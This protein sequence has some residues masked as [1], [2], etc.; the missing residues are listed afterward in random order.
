[1]FN[2]ESYLQPEILD[3]LNNSQKR[4]DFEALLPQYIEFCQNTFASNECTQILSK[5]NEV[6][7]NISVS[8]K[9]LWITNDYEIKYDKDVIY[10]FKKN[11][12][13]S[14]RLIQLMKDEEHILNKATILAN[15]NLNTLNDFAIFVEKEVYPYI[16]NHK[17]MN[18]NPYFN[19]LNS[20][21]LKFTNKNDYFDKPS[22]NGY[23]RIEVTFIHNNEKESP[24]VI[25]YSLSMTVEER[26]ALK[27]NL[28]Q[29]VLSYVYKLEYIDVQKVKDNFVEGSFKRETYFTTTDWS[30]PLKYYFYNNH[31]YI[32]SSYLSA[33]QEEK[34]DL[35]AK[36]EN[37]D[38]ILKAF[39]KYPLLFKRDFRIVDDNNITDSF[40]LINGAISISCDVTSKEFKKF[41]DTLIKGID[42]VINFEQNNVFPSGNFTNLKRYFILEDF[43]QR[44]NEDEYVFYRF[45][46]SKN[47]VQKRGFKNGKLMSSNQMVK[48]L[49]S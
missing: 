16:N 8:Q 14:D 4:N 47:K 24:F 12:T 34:N 6:L 44:V 20:Y 28:A 5:I 33:T 41:V 37:R 29:K 31:F 19:S 40:S 11:S 39:E 9:H 10:K 43:R 18:N 23:T 21:E 30:N 22:P 26:K 17:S 7:G 36:I 27:N 3:L 1:M 49:R 45:R 42:E 15:N 35:Y 48:F 2:Y 46:G 13:S 38:A 25:D 32:T